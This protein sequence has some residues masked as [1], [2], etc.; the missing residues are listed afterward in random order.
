MIIP[1]GYAQVT[2]IF[3]SGF[4]PYGAVTTY[5]IGDI[6]LF[7][8]LNAL[9]S[10]LY[11]AFQDHVMGNLSSSVNHDTCRVKAGPNETGPVGEF[12]GVEVGGAGGTFASPNLAYLV[13]KHTALGGRK[14]RG[15]MFLP[16]VT[17]GGIGGS[18]D[19]DLTVLGDFTTN[20]ANWLDAL[21][22][23]GVEPVVL[24]SDETAPTPIT[25]FVIDPKVATQRNRLRR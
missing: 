1:V 2:H 18:G 11:D 5:G 25:A 23:V 6:G 19:L 8:D 24:H 22:G 9:A 15:R 3:S 14:G 17:E 7:P 16:G 12:T 20:L 4:L 13:E 21:G 10:D